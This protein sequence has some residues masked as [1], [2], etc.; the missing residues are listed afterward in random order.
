MEEEKKKKNSDW[1]RQHDI[2]VMKDTSAFSR[3]H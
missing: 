2:I 1:Y 3:E